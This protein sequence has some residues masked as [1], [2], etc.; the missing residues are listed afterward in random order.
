MIPAHGPAIDDGEGLLL[1]YIAHRMAR[2]EQV[3]SALRTAPVDG[4][5]PIDVVPGLYPEVPGLFHPLAARQVLAHLLK[6]EAEGKVERVGGGSAVP[7][8]PIYMPAAGTV[9][10]PEAAFR[11]LR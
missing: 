6:L 11:L 2:E 5:Y 8:Q 1:R 10:A 3:L 7:G 4:V 9:A